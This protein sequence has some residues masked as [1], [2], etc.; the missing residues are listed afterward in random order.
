MQV[1]RLT[2]ELLRPVPLRPLEATASVLRPGKRV[3][4]VGASLLAPG[5]DGSVEVARAQALRIRTAAVA[6]VVATTQPPPAPPPHPDSP[7][8]AEA[9]STMRRT[10]FAGAVDIR[11]VKGSWDEEGP[12]TI[13]TRLVSPVVEDEPPSPLQRA[14]AA[15][16]FGNGVSHLLSFN[17]HVFINPDLTVSLARVPEG[18]WI[19]FDVVSRLSPDG[20]GHAES[21]IFDPVG[22]VGRAV[23]SLIVDER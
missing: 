6:G 22:P 16:D 14:T 23:Q 5:P 4:L 11:F 8:F 12:V 10:A 3:Q 18:E 17:T 1:V 9:A 21:Q 20:F 7:P 13:W 19:G 2:V 15:A